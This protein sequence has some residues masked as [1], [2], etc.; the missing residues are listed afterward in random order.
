MED[1]ITDSSPDK[2]VYPRAVVPVL[3]C[4]VQRLLDQQ[5]GNKSEQGI[6]RKQTESFFHSM[7]PSPMSIGTYLERVAAFTMCS[8]ESLILALIYLDRIVKYNP[9]FVINSHSIHRLLLTS[10]VVATKFHDDHL[11]KNSFYARVGGVE[12]QEL[13]FLEREFLAMIQYDVALG[14]EESYSYYYEQVVMHGSLC[15]LRCGS[16]EIPFF[17][18]M[19]DGT[20]GYHDAVDSGK[21]TVGLPS[22]AH[23]SPTTSASSGYFGFH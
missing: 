19:E 3:A 21:S 20:Y 1:F 10:V 23:W 13:N 4:L 14:I 22:N 15:E 11:F 12:L 7:V 17:P 5:N 6:D 18:L 16:I 9:E 8:G 2:T